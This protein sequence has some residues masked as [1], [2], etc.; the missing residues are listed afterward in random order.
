MKDESKTKKQLISELHGARGRLAEL[1]SAASDSMAFDRV[2][3]TLVEKSFG[4]MYIVQGE[5]FKYVNPN[6]EICLGYTKAELIGTRADLVVHPEDKDMV[7]NNAYAMLRGEP[8][9]PYQFRIITKKGEIRWIMETLSPIILDGKEA[10]LGSSLDITEYRRAQEAIRG[11]E[12]RLKDIIDFLP[13]ATLVIDKDGKI[14]AWNRAI[15]EMTGYPAKEMLG[16]GDYEYSIPFYGERRPILIDLVGLPSETIETEYAFLRRNKNGVLMGDAKCPMNR[17]EMRFLSGWAASIYNLKGE[18]AGAIESIRDLTEKKQAEEELQL[19]KEKLE[20]WVGELERRNREINLMREMDELLQTCDSIVES[21]PIIEQF[22]PRLFAGTS[23]ALFSF[24]PSRKNLEA[25]LSWGRNL[26]TSHVFAP[27]DCWALRRG[28]AHVVNNSKYSSG[29][30]CRHMSS[31]SLDYLEVPMIAPG[32]VLGLLHIEY[33]VETPCDRRA[34]EMALIVSEHLSLS[35]SN[36]KL[37]ETLHA[38][39][40][41]DPLTGLFNRRYMEETLEREIYRATRTGYPIGI[42]MLD[43]DHFKRLNDTYGHDAG[44][45]VLI[46]I[47]KKI[48]DSIR[49]S[50]VACRYGGEEFILILPNADLEVTRHRAEKLR[51][52]IESGN[53]VYHLQELGAITVSLGVAGYPDHAQAMESILKKADEALY[54]AKKL[55]RNRV[56]VSPDLWQ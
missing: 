7:R 40:V 50:D 9:T 18:R 30:R 44:D 21:Y 54:L 46:E 45:L 5:R 27:V 25:A 24:S 22:I 4:I 55:G 14:I 16:K 43:I 12:Q 11:S 31:S 8:V 1:K 34:E 3:K 36:L 53:F 20:T 13:D 6:A 48:R 2:Y 56:E 29:L 39:S 38:Q 41:R 28:Q 42:I 10:I 17:K 15:E 47:G 51:S 37:R 23:G 35:L 32:D 33:P 49:V 52:D 19:A 26:E